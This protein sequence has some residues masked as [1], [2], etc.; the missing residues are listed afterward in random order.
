MGSLF[1]SK[2]SESHSLSSVS[3]SSSSLGSSGSHSLSSVSGS[4]GSGREDKSD[5]SNNTFQGF[6]LKDKPS[7]KSLE[8][9]Y[10]YQTVL[11]K[12]EKYI[13]ENPEMEG[14]INRKF[15]SIK[16][17]A[18]ILSDREKFK[19]CFFGEY[20]KIMIASE[21]EKM[22]NDLKENFTAEEMDHFKKNMQNIIKAMNDQKLEFRLSPLNVLN[23]YGLSAI[24]KFG[25]IIINKS[26]Y[27]N[28]NYGAFHS[29]LSL[30]GLI[31]EWN[32]SSLVIPHLDFEK[33]VYYSYEIKDGF[34]W[35]ILKSIKNGLINIVNFITSFITKS[36]HIKDIVERELDIICQECVDFNTNRF[37]GF[38]SIN[39]QFFVDTILKGIG[40]E[41][42]FE[43]EMEREIN[44][45]KKN[46]E[47]DF[48]FR[49]HKFNTRKQLDDYA[50]LHFFSLK[51]DERK[52]LFLFKNTFEAR[53]M[54]NIDKETGKF[55]NST[56]EK[57][58]GTTKEAEE[59]W[60]NFEIND[61]IGEGFLSFL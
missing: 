10:G 52:L 9:N 5:N 15:E 1:S 34:L 14:I 39:C 42:K 24:V 43:G 28:W 60:K 50:K 58:L 45:F 32:D 35:R 55:K 12:L 57:E 30:N 48:T 59:M 2:S 6:V 51:N 36:W 21:T 7:E 17:F 53:R 33:M 25:S 19:S 38:T 37:Y 22:L 23:I 27:T 8:Y 26:G 46:G 18:I 16:D 54:A 11:K 31:L 20:S 13:K 56:D 4:S 47:L 40:A 61:K 44:Y 29:F 41:L 49:E 3:N